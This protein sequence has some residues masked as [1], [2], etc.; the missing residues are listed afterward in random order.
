MKKLSTV[1]AGILIPWAATAHYHCN[2]AAKSQAQGT[3]LYFQNGEDFLTNSG[4]VLTLNQT[5]THP[6]YFIT[7]DVNNITFTSTGTGFLE[8]PADGAQVWLRIVSVS[9]PPGGNFAVWDVSQYFYQDGNGDHF[10]EDENDATAVTFTLPTGTVNGTNAIL[11]SENF[12][13]P[14]ASAFGHIHGRMWSADKAG[15]YV[16]TVQAYDGGTN[17]TDGGPIQSPSGRLQIY[18]QAG[19][20]ISGVV[21]GTNEVDISFPAKIGDNPNGTDY[22]LEASPNPADPLSWQTVA[23]PVLGDD[24]FH[25][26]SDPNWNAAHRFYR[27]RL[28]P[29]P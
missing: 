18:F 6:G 17:G 4:F 2:V 27:L 25:V 1:L 19:D 21:V 20:Q 16:V 3:P 22:Y 14:G 12:D 23:G 9:G 5:N 8:P 26:L 15:L 11:L 24:H 10:N 7:S 13:E 29:A 28:E